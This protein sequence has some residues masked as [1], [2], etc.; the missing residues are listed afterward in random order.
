MLQ[1][2]QLKCQFV[3]GEIKNIK[4]LSPPKLQINKLTAIFAENVDCMGISINDF[5]F[6]ECD[7]KTDSNGKDR[8]MESIASST[9][10][11]VEIALSIEQPIE[12]KHNANGKCFILQCHAHNLFT[13]TK[14]ICS[15][16][17]LL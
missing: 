13:S 12:I 2:I 1:G 7:T 5:A 6:D 11:S 3:T 9:E 17:F 15:S 16:F 4:E 14:I 8:D 10:Q